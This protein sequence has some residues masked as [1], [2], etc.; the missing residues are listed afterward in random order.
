MA[1]SIS[2]KDQFIWMANRNFSG[3][4]DFLLVIA[5]ETATTPEERIL[6]ERFREATKAFFPGYSFKIEREFSSLEER[7]FWC[8][9]FYNLA[10]AIFL[11]KVGN[12]ENDF[13]QS[14]AIG[15]AFVV[16]RFLTESVREMERNWSPTTDD[17]LRAEEFYGK[18]SNIK[19]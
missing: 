12:Q 15:E 7:K 1:S 19:I 10:R 2:Y 13:W 14:I 4:V 5:P 3:M 9:C 16:A 8:R 6:I 17:S 18:L 11:R